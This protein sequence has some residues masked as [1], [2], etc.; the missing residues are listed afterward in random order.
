MRVTPWLAGL[1]LLAAL[2]CG[3]RWHRAEVARAVEAAAAQRSM[4][5]LAAVVAADRAERAAKHAR[6]SLASARA[7]AERDARLR[8][9]RAAADASADSLGRLLATLAPLLPDTLAPYAQRILAEWAAHLDADLRERGAADSTIG[10][11][12]R[13]LA[14]LE[15]RYAADLSAVNVQ[16]AEALR[17]LQAANA[18][19]RPGLLRRAVAALPWAAAAFLAG[20]SLSR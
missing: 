11:L 1:A 10:G 5:S 20:L 14:S 3:W 13:D 9:A 6:D 2:F 4:D 7:I 18:R 19:A 15:G 17:Q 8:A 16:L 12:K